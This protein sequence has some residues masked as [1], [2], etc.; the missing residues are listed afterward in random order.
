[1]QAITTYV[2]TSTSS[3][4]ITF[5]NIPQTYTDLKIV[6]SGR[7]GNSTSGDQ[8]MQFNDNSQ[9][10]YSTTYLQGNGASYGGRQSNNT[11]IIIGQNPGTNSTAGNFSSVELTIPNYRSAVHKQITGFHMTQF[12]NTTGYNMIV[13]AGLWRSIE[14]IRKIILGQGMAVGAT[15]T[16]YGITR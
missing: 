6:Y 16:L 8:Y 3:P 14:P 11:A 9:T 13:P 15:A 7:V 10:L 2:V 1:M 5:S 4:S 12:N